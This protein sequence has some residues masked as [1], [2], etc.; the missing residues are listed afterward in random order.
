M[1]FQY[2]LILLSCFI[3]LSCKKKEKIVEVEKEVIVYQDPVYKWKRVDA[4]KNAGSEFIR[5]AHRASGGFIYFAEN[6]FNVVYDSVKDKFTFLQ[7]SPFERQLK[8]LLTNNYVI[9]R[10]DFAINILPHNNLP[11]FYLAYSEKQLY[12]QNIDSNFNNFRIIYPVFEGEV[13]GNNNK[14][15]MCY[16][17]KNFIGL[18]YLAVKLKFPAMSWF[19]DPSFVVQVDTFKKIAD[20]TALS[21]DRMIGNVGNN[22]LFTMGDI[23]NYVL[24]DNLDTVF[25]NNT[26]LYNDVFSYKGTNYAIVRTV[27]KRC[28]QTCLIKTLDDGLTWQELVCGINNNFEDLTFCE[29]GDKLI[30]YSFA[31]QLWEVT[32][33]ENSISA[34][35]L[36]NN[37]LENKR[38]KALNYCNNRVFI[39]TESGVFE[40]PY[41]EFIE[42]K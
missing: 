34:K 13:I 33:T 8:P 11:D 5:N 35:E 17:T 16:Q 26:Y 32:L 6:S 9:Q 1:Q 38:I 23:K 12:M 19:N 10:S 28:C 15:L 3:L 39:S 4:F 30:A 37:G 27:G 29:I 42:Y 22:L 18:N 25:V 21:S 2:I 14:L 20:P 7:G 24:D 40:R 36:D 41:N 31:N